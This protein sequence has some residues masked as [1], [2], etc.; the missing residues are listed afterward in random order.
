VQL[1]KRAKAGAGSKA[2]A[3]G[4]KAQGFLEDKGKITDVFRLTLAGAE[5]CKNAGIATQEAYQ[6]VKQRDTAK[7]EPAK[8]KK[9]ASAKTPA[10][11][12]TA[13]STFTYHPNPKRTPHAVREGTKIATIIDLTSRAQGVTLSELQTLMSPKSTVRGVLQY[14]LNALVGY[15]CVYDGKVVRLILPKGMNAPLPHVE[16]KGKKTVAAKKGA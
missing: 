14:D 3:G 9:A 7:S 1:S 11:K 16:A 10:A 6:D 4:L 2:I 12:K 8:Q 15:G 5:Y 13:D